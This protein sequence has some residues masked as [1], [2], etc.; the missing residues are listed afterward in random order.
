MDILL[1]MIIGGMVGML[2]AA[3]ILL[4]KDTEY[5]EVRLR[6]IVTASFGVIG[7]ILMAL[8]SRVNF[9]EVAKV[10]GLAIY[11]F[12][13]LACSLILGLAIGGLLVGLLI[14][15][16]ILSL[17][18]VIKNLFGITASIDEYSRHYSEKLRDRIFGGALI[19]G[20]IGAIYGAY[21]SYGWRIWQTLLDHV[22]S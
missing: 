16:L 6:Q 22:A 9:V 20:G 13:S 4:I 2:L 12:L 14:Y 15:V 11:H 1:R 3:L 10:V 21:L 8:L 7:V 18:V 19:L 17:V 5:W